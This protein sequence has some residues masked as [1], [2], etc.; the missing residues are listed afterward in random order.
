MFRQVAAGS[1]V[2][3]V[4][5]AISDLEPDE[6]SWP[7]TD[8]IWVVGRCELPWLQK[9]VGD[10]QPDEIEPGSSSHGEVYDALC[11]RHPGT[12]LHWIWWD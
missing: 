7:F 9:L 4:Y 5:A 8:A 3:A 1:G 10:L 6:E 2:V 11:T 12:P